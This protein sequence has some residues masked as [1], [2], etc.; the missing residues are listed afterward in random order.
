MGMDKTLLI[1]IEGSASTQM[2]VASGR[3]SSGGTAS[4]SG[5]S[6]KKDKDEERYLRLKEYFLL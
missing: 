4:P 2:G 3:G 6:A 5:D 1:K